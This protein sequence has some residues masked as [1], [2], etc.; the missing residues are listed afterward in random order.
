MLS[1]DLQELLEQYLNGQL[2]G[3]ALQNF[4][5]RIAEDKGLAL[6]V[7]FQREMQTFLAESPENELRKTLQMLSN[8]VV[9]PK[10]DEAKGWFWWLLPAEGSPNVLDWLIGHPVRH[11]AWLLPLLLTAGWWFFHTNDT[12]IIDSP[13]VNVDSLKKKDLLPKMDTIN[14][15]VIDAK[16]GTVDTTLER[17][18]IPETTIPKTPKKDKQPPY[19]QQEASPQ[20]P[21][22]DLP[23]ELLQLDTPDAPIVNQPIPNST[24]T[25]FYPKIDYREMSSLPSPNEPSRTY[26]VATPPTIYWYNSEVEPVIDSFDLDMYFGPSPAL[27]SLIAQNF[28]QQNIGIEILK[29]PEIAYLSKDT[30]ERYALNDLD[31]KLIIKT[32]EPF[33]KKDLVLYMRDNRGNPYGPLSLSDSI[34][35]YGEN[36]YLVTAQLPLW[37]STPRLAYYSLEDYQSGQTYFIEKIPIIPQDSLL[38]KWLF[39]TKGEIMFSAIAS[40]SVYPSETDFFEPNPRLDTLITKNGKNTDSK[41]TFFPS[42]PDTI[43]ATQN[44]SV[45][46]IEVTLTTKDKLLNGNIMGRLRDNY[47]SIAAT[48]DI[49]PEEKLYKRYGTNTY[50]CSLT[51]TNASNPSQNGLYYY[52]IFGFGVGISEENSTKLYHIGKFIYFKNN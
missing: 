35:P 51:L 39:P 22:T 41:T 44:G 43:Y 7:E 32:T 48:I 31:L 6:E 17:K 33:I 24:D 11:L 2:T 50:V 18:K 29:Q 34:V 27:D 10:A 28:N 14:Q 19:V 42:L 38:N 46:T 16:E 45:S 21:K 49:L 15:I 4:E 13:I 36:A 20:T 30:S 1:P 3:E 5:K 9:A 40:I 23:T 37:D 52:E 26:V 8:Q 12:T 25:V 47:G